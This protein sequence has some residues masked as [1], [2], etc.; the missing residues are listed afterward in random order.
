MSAPDLPVVAILLALEALLVTRKRSKRAALR[1]NQHRRRALR[2]LSSDVPLARVLP[3]LG[4]LPTPAEELMGRPAAAEVI[5]QAC[6]VCG[7][8]ARHGLDLP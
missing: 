1:C 2:V 5:R 7:R 4:V 8:C 3:A 6:K